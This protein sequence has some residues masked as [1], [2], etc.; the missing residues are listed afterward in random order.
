MKALARLRAISNDTLIRVACVLGLV[1]LPLMV[2]S[3]VIPNVW[4]VL[5]ALS[6]GQAIGTLSFVLYLLV[7]AR[8]LDLL[9]RL[10]PDRRSREG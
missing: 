2:V 7:I 6:V 10:R 8:D 5:V 9:G 4:T 1:A 3:V